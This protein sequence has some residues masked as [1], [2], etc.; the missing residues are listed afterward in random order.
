MTHT[1]APAPLL[2]FTAEQ[3]WNAERPEALVICCSDGRWHAQLEEFIV[4]QVSERSDVYAV[5]GGP[6]ALSRWSSSFGDADAAQRAME[7][8]MEHHQLKSIW[9]VSHQDC[10]FY[11]QRFG[12]LDAQYMLRRQQDDLRRA[13]DA[14]VAAYP[15]LEV[16]RV[17]AARE[18]RRVTFTV[19]A[20]EG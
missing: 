15:K 17:Y 11:R 18:N 10:A 7:F 16:H 2:R 20:E 14:I 19:L 8:L 4:A 13:H 1:L 3:P 6:A 12:P 5:P 9:L